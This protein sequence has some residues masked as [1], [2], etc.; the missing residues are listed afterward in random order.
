MNKKQRL[1]FGVAII[2]ALLGYLAYMGVASNQYEVSEAVAAKE[3]LAGKIILVN[4]SL[5]TGTDKWDPL[6]R[7]LTFKM[8]DGTTTIDVNYTGEKPDIPPGYTNIQVVATGQFDN[9]E[10]KAYKMLTKCPS[11]YEASPGNIAK[12]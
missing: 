4:G 6:S 1:I 11:K 8:T 2:I 10:F 12:Q 7:T 9:N 5:I 3:K